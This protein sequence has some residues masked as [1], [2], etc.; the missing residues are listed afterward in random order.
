MIEDVIVDPD[1]QQPI[2]GSPPPIGGSPPQDI[3]TGEITSDRA[4]A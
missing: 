4:T 1:P 3:P 2:G